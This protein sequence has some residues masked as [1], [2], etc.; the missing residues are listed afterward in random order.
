MDSQVLRL[1]SAVG[2]NATD[3]GEVG[4]PFHWKR[5][6]TVNWRP[7]I[8]QPLPSPYFLYK[9]FRPRPQ[10]PNSRRARSDT[11]F[12]RKARGEV[13]EGTGCYAPLESSKA[14]CGQED[15][16]H[17]AQDKVTPGAWI[18]TKRAGLPVDQLSQENLQ[19][20]FAQIGEGYAREL[21]SHLPLWMRLLAS[22]EHGNLFY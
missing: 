4:N 21:P 5:T 3:V 16:Y 2:L 11:T 19:I 7:L 14:V 1:E 17:Y 22:I 18:L 10:K 20:T 13:A 15:S 8:V 9:A 12:L 6:N